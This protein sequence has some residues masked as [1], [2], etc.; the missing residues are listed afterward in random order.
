MVRHVLALLTSAVL[1]VLGIMFSMVVLAVIAILGLS[2]WGYLWWKTRNLRRETHEQAA[3][4]QV[5]DGEA[6]VVEDYL[7]KTKSV[8]PGEPPK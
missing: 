2:V 5:I 1:L 7:V 4:G 3:D 8:L 6:I